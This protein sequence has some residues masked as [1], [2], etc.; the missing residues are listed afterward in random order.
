MSYNRYNNNVLNKE[1]LNKLLNK[2]NRRYLV[3]SFSVGQEDITSF[4]L[5]WVFLSI[6][7]FCSCI[8]DSH[9]RTCKGN[10]VLQ[11]TN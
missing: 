1:V 11:L 7:E 5:I 4:S 2:S 8:F 6:L 3:R 9:L 10:N